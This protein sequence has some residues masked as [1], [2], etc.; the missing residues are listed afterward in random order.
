MEGRGQLDVAGGASTRGRIIRALALGLFLFAAALPANAQATF[1]VA[2]ASELAR[3]VKQ[4]ASEENWREIV[5]QLEG[6]PAKD[7]ELYFYYGTALAQ[8][9]RLDDASR[10]FLTGQRLAP[11]DQRFPIELAGVAFK[12]KHYAAASAGLRRALRIDPTDRYANDFLGTVY[13]LEGNLDAALKY[14]NRIGKP[15]I[16]TVQPDHPLRIRPALLDRA[17]AFSPASELRLA[18]L[19]SSR[20]RLAGLEI[21]PAPRIQ[22]AA[23]PED[24]FDAILNLQERNGWGNNV[25]EALISTFSGVGYQTIYPEY[26]NIGGSAINVTSLVRW[27]EQ[28]RRLAASLSG[29]FHQNPKWRDRLEI[30]LRNENWDIRDSFAGPSPSL[31]ALNLRREAASAG[32]DSF[33]SGRWGWSAG[34][35]FSH[36]DY[37]NVVP[38]STL[39]PQL[40]LEGLQLKQLAQVHYTLL[41]VPEHRFMLNTSAS[42]QVGRIWSQPA[43]AFT[44]LQGSLE[45]QWYPR[46][47][48]DD[49]AVQTKV[50]SGAMSGRPPFDELYMLGMERDNDL[51]MRGHIGTRDG[52]KGSAPLGRRYFLGNSEIDKNLYSNGL[53]TV[54]LSPFVDTG[55]ITDPSDNL[56]SQKWLWDTGAQAK[57]RVLGVG[58]TFVYGKDLRSGNNAFY[59]TAGR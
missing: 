59:F 42:S 41:Q 24:K 58:V 25:W 51:W 9:G 43:H 20:V 32:I 55:K 18:D 27:D 26:D 17:L 16:E 39:T 19:E 22:L 50:R 31:G 4:L 11:R 52:R 47:T 34:V 35:E 45:A 3:R 57:L 5:G 14:W 15:Y 28:K 23:R 10:A 53:I 36:R 1:P 54:K 56:G 12:Q 46:A 49:Y 30:D 21:F 29:P 40:L 13:F 6:F 37:R 44:K 48:G 2:S 33:N 38:G 8:L 7:A